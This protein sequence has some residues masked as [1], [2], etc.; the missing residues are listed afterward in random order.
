MLQRLQCLRILDGS[1]VFFI[2]SIQDMHDERILIF[3]M[4]RER[5][6]GEGGRERKRE[7]RY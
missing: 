1:F 4:N 2:R 5:E 3:I 6:S 7:M